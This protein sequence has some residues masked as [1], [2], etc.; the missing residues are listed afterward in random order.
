MQGTRSIPPSH[1]GTQAP[2][3]WWLCCLLGHQSSLLDPLHP[4]SNWVKREHRV[5]SQSTGKNSV[6]YPHLIAGEVQKY[7]M[8]VWSEGTG[9]GIW[10]EHSNVSATL[11]LAIIFLKK[12]FQKWL[13]Y[14]HNLSKL[15][16][17]LLSLPW[18]SAA[19]KY[20]LVDFLCWFYVSLC[21]VRVF[22]RWDKQIRFKIWLLWSTN[23]L[24]GLFLT[25]RWR[26][27]EGVPKIGLGAIQ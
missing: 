3:M 23:Q 22:F 16:S 13:G 8:A 9:N 7:C 18:S 6:S 15:L 1:S 14:Q 21:C 5:H 4:T 2:S 24:L 27:R 10:W 11:P 17:H 12:V 20:I 26:S 25:N 19:W